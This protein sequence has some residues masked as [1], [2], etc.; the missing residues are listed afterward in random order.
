MCPGRHLAKDNAFFMIA[1]VLHVFDVVPGL[2]ENGKELDP[3]V[4]MTSG[5][6][7][8]VLPADITLWVKHGTDYTTTGILTD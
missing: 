1:S 6:L 7:S 4:E 5:L 2:N 3:A 8:Y